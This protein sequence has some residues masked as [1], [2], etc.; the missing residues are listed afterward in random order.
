MALDDSCLHLMCS[1]VLCASLVRQLQRK[2]QRFQGI[3]TVQGVFLCVNSFL[4]L[5]LAL[6]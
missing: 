3:S 4:L 2:I 6:F 5:H 1:G